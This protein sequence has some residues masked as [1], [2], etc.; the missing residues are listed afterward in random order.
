MVF[1]A[2]ASEER[3]F[4]YYVARA[5]QAQEDNA[6][7]SA[8]LQQLDIMGHTGYS[9]LHEIPDFN[10]QTQVPLDP[11]HNADLGVTKRLFSLT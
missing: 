11:M 1:G 9:P 6:G 10:P 2:S 3:S 4:D 7:R 5:L 8:D